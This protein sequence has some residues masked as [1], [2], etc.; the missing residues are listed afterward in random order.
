MLM[1]YILS[2]SNRRILDLFS[3]NFKKI[4]RADFHCPKICSSLLNRDLQLVSKFEKHRAVNFRDANRFFLFLINVL[5][6]F[7]SS[8][9]AANSWRNQRQNKFFWRKGR[10]YGTLKLLLHNF[11]AVFLP[12]EQALKLLSKISNRQK[13]YDLIYN[14]KGCE[15]KNET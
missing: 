1:V 7:F 2:F 9:D 3:M 8:L 4:N 10:Y 15:Q 6:I 14:K 11:F 5:T 12:W 13:K